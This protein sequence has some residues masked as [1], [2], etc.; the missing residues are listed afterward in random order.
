MYK[1][2]IDCHVHSDNSFDGSDP[3][4]K[5]CEWA[6]H[7]DLRALA[8]TD[9]CEINRFY[10][11]SFD[12]STINSYFSCSKARSV[13]EGMLVIMSGLELGQPLQDIAAAEKAI[14]LCSFDF[15]LG[16]LHNIK[17][18]EDFYFLDYK[19]EDCGKLLNLYFDELTEMVQWGKFDSLA[20]ITYPLRYMKKT[21]SV[22]VSQYYK[23]IDEILKLLA[24][25]NIALEIN[26]A[27][28]RK[29][30]EKKIP[31]EDF[32]I[33]RRFKRL[34]GKYITVGSDAHK[35]TDLGAD[36]DKAIELAECAGFENIVMFMNHFPIEIPIIK[37]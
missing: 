24:E 26:T 21:V 29:S 35:Y 19:K 25:K 14:N 13:F 15:I 5:M 28:V 1:T 4:M 23:K 36:I 22:D 20:H 16:S 12:K 33:V 17:D 10:K 11:D 37:L 34:G 2:M 8:I 18:Y 27:A 31:D 6:Q 9:H 32:E 3:V 30:D 7:K